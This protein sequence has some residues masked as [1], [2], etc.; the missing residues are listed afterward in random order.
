MKI[1]KY[2]IFVLI[3]AAFIIL[4]WVGFQLFKKDDA[5]AIHIAFVGPLLG[6]EAL[7]GRTMK[8]AVQLYFDNINQQGGI[9]GKKLVL[10]VFDDR[11]DIYRAT[12]IAQKIVAQNRALAVIGHNYSACSINAGKVYYKYQIPAITPTSTN[13][14]VTQKND[15][16]FRTIFNDN[17]QAYFLANYTKHVLKKDAISIIHTNDVYG[18]YLAEKFKEAAQQ[19]N[20]DIKYQWL[21]PSNNKLLDTQIQQI[22]AELKTKL[23]TAP[24]FLSTHTIEGIHLVKSIREAGLK[25]LLIAPDSYASKKFRQHFAEQ[26]Q[27]ERITPGFYTN[28]VYVSTPFL[29]DTADR[30][31]YYFNKIYQQAYSEEP[32]FSLSWQAFYA[33]DAAAVIVEAIKKAKIKGLQTTLVEDRKKIRDTLKRFDSPDKAVKGN[34]GLNYFDKNGDAL[35]PIAMG[36]YKNGHLIS[37]HTQLQLAPNY[38]QE[39]SLN[40][41]APQNLSNSSVKDQ[42]FKTQVA[43]TS[44]KLNSINNFDHKTGVVNLDFFVWFRFDGAEKIHPQNIEFLNTIEPVKIEEFPLEKINQETY[45]LYRVNGNFKVGVPKTYIF[46]Y[47]LNISFR[48]RTLNKS[49]LLYVKDILGMKL[50]S[51]KIDE[52]Q[53]RST[54]GDWIIKSIE[55]FHGS[56]K[57]ELLGNPKYFDS[58][59]FTEYST[60]NTEIIINHSAYRYHLSI[61]TELA[62]QLFIISI[63]I[64]ILLILFSYK[65]NMSLISLKYLWFL[66][67]I[68][69]LILL[70][71]SEIF[72][73]HW[74]VDSVYFSSVIKNLGLEKIVIV[75]IRILWWIIPA[76]ILIMAVK[77]FLWLSLEEKTGRAVPNLIRFLTAL[78]IYTLAIFGIIAF[79]FER[80]ITSLLATSG[81]AAM[82]IGLAVQMNLSNIFSGIA[83]SIEHS[84]RIG[85]WVQI[86]ELEEGKVVNVNWRV[87]QI[88][89]RKGYILSIPNSIAA[90]S[91][92]RN[93]SYPDNQ[94]WLKL[95]IPIDPKYDP[96]IVEKVIFQAILS[97]KKHIVKD[98]KP[99]VWLNDILAIEVSEHTAEYAVFF[100]TKDY[101]YKFRVLKAVWKNIWIGLNQAGIIVAANQISNEAIT[102][103]PNNILNKHQLENMI[104][105]N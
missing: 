30:Q 37:T 89:T 23:Y 22:I 14:E 104:K 13:V 91:N 57:Q 21:L 51:N 11:N 19:L 52:V 32:T 74:L 55:F 31:A 48:H 90:A 47:P 72:V 96:R 76:I 92:I 105:E 56:I 60:F 85:E 39:L 49:Q 40:L 20:I 101:Q 63:I 78:V 7:V 15:W 1:I 59:Q 34:T 100:K 44:I 16:Y 99:I 75:S 36:I 103:L 50:V 4:A 28:G 98:F 6:D 66:Q 53:K 69:V 77:R 70:I 29:F 24:I 26:Y 42:I 65:K 61:P 71:S 43:Y 88:K 82:I 33:V 2:L 10:D 67:S 18:S 80:P 54:L 12:K 25:N 41:A 38:Q 9:H 64:T 27:A 62:S 81:V 79:V 95:T 73:I 17:L 35:K 86:G 5:E 94:Y 87:T 97:V 83:L 68:A 8:K 84:F 3:F 58:K 45:Q 46:Q 102:A 93:F